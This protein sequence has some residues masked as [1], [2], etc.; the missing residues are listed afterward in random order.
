MKKDYQIPE[1]EL[2]SLTAR[3]NVTSGDNSIWKAALAAVFLI[4]PCAAKSRT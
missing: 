2:I 1:V 3:E 4:N